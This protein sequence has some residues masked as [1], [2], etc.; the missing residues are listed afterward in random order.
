MPIISVSVFIFLFCASTYRITSYLL[1]F[2][3]LLSHLLVELLVA[4]GLR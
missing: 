1:E 4:M 3:L 2:C